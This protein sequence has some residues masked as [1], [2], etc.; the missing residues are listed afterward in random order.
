MKK[1]VL[2]AILILFVATGC[3]K[4]PKLAN[5]EEA[6]VS[7]D[8]AKLNISVDKLFNG[9]KEKY[10]INVLIDLIDRTILLD[11]YPDNKKEADKYIDEQLTTVKENYKDENGEYDESALL[12]A[13]SNYYGMTTIAEFEEM[14]ELSYYRTKAVEDY[15][16]AEVT[17]KQIKKYYEDEI[18]GDIQCKH[19]LITS[20]ATE[21]MTD[22]EKKSAED[23]ALKQAKNIIKELDKGAKFVDLAK[24]YSED[25]SNSE[26]GGD[27]GYFNK[28][29]MVASFE[30]AAY[31]LKI[32]TYTKT[33]VK[34]EFGYHIILKTAEKDKPSLKDSKEKIIETLSK[35]LQTNDKTISVNALADLR[36]EYGFNIEDS[37]LKSKYSTLISNQLLSLRQQAN[38]NS[39]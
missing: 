21:D 25:K 33:P 22:E 7:F 23:A 14:L 5:G 2:L 17:D 19:I 27:L 6:M 15:A 30:K 18:V 3:G 36:K 16:K 4:N 29:D 24:K 13:L 26:K 1:K 37:D 32:K 11:K 20:K 34:S 9:L 28:G 38:Q 8:N 12:E 31:E 39:Q 35:E 10:A